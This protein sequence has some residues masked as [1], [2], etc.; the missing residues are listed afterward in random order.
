MARLEARMGLSDN[1]PTA[2][3]TPT[4]VERMSMHC[5]Y[6]IS[7][8]APDLKLP[9]TAPGTQYLIDTDPARDPQLNPARALNL[10]KK[11]VLE[12]GADADVVLMDHT[13]RVMKTFV[14]GKLVFDR[15]WT[16]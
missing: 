7:G 3:I 8:D 11:G 6:A 5:W 9:A 14:K 12:P 16:N 1:V 4:W 15:L 2:N 13:F 10:D